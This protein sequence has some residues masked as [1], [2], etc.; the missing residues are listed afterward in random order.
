MKNLKLNTMTEEDLLELSEQFAFDAEESGKI[1]DISD[2][3]YK[4]ATSAEAKEYHTQTLISDLEEFIELNDKSFK[5]S[6]ELLK[7]FIQEQ[8]TKK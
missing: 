4:G 7:G 3:Y 1:L 6:K 5:D 8:L 2:V